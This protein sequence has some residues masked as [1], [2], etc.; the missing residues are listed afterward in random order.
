MEEPDRHAMTAVALFKLI[1]CGLTDTCF[2][3]HHKG[4]A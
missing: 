1:T 3:V 2:K 4:I